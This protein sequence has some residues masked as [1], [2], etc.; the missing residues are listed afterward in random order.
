MLCQTKNSPALFLLL[1]L[2][3]LPPHSV[4]ST[5]DKPNEWLVTLI[6][7]SINLELQ[8]RC[9]RGGDDDTYDKV[10]Y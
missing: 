10:S 4:T 6:S 1:L 2:L 3:L 7:S 5:L 8:V 9:G